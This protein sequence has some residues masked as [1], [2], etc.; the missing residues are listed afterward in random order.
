MLLHESKLVK[1]FG[2]DYQKAENSQ[3]LPDNRQVV[4]IVTDV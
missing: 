4:Q 1:R 3:E 2:W